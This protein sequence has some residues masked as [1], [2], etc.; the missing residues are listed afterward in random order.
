MPPH[1]KISARET[2]FNVFV[3]KE[4]ITAAPPNPGGQNAA[5]RRPLEQ[6]TSG[7]P[8]ALPGD[9]DELLRKNAEQWSSLAGSVKGQILKPL[10]GAGVGNSF[11]AVDGFFA[12]SSSLFDVAMG[13]IAFLKSDAHDE[14]IDAVCAATLQLKSRLSETKKTLIPQDFTERA[15]ACAKGRRFVREYL[16]HNV[17]GSPYG[18]EQSGTQARSPA[19]PSG[20]RTDTTATLA[21]TSAS[22]QRDAGNADAAEK[23]LPVET[24]EQ[25]R[26]PSSP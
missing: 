24:P 10:A 14:S 18:Q 22:P 23:T 5:S 17:Y 8:L 11:A 15:R 16:V 9:L 21:P 7:K 6:K 13:V 19:L 26:L 25:S 2:G 20:A 1:G 3:E 4:S 12:S